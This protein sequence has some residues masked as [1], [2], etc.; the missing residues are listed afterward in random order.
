MA[1]EDLAV[2]GD[3]YATEVQRCIQN[4]YEVEGLDPS[5]V[6]HLRATVVIRIEADGK[7]VGFKIE[8][9]SGLTAFD[10]AVGRAVQRC[11]RVSAPPVQMRRQVRYDGI[12]IDFKP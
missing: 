6:N 11:G 7:I 8:K 12:Q 1:D 10:A 9:S 4:H 3:R 5:K 2:Q